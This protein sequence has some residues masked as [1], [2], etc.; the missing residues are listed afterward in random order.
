MVQLPG[1]SAAALTSQIK[2]LRSSLDL[3]QAVT[4]AE[5]PPFDV[6][7]S[8]ALY[9]RIMQP[10]IE[11]LKGIDTLFI[12]SDGPLASLPLALL[13]TRASNA[14][15]AST[16]YRN[17]RWLG[18]RYALVTLPSVNAL[19]A[20][21][22]LA[23]PSAA[24]LPLLALA[25]PAMRGS[26]DVRT[27]T[28]FASLRGSAAGSTLAQRTATSLCQM[29]ALPDTRREAL[30]LARQLGSSPGSILLGS[31]ASESGLRARQA[32]GTLKQYRTLLFA[33][34]GLLA[35]PD[36]TEEPALV[37]S[38]PPDCKAAAD[39]EDGLLTASEIA[40]F[41]LDA[42]LVVLSG[43]NTASGLETVSARPLSGLAAAFQ[44]AGAR[45]LLVSHW[46]VDSAA[47][48]DLMGAMFAGAG[49]ITATRLQQS[50]RHI[51]NS[52]GLLAYRAHPAFWAAF[53][54]VGD[55]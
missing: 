54:L 7:A 36:A 2:A 4:A 20:F 28:A 55:R 13:V 11:H 49:P 31:A 8:Q 19:V 40:T 18:D 27:L 25:D 44:Y 53:V 21:R 30:A 1:T 26:V 47:T 3:S 41:T 23:R 51:R 12:A 10:L 35:G 29:Q 48:A 15:D 37:L 34:H 46:S 43:C 9:A 52:T 24:Q 33:T 5:L 16:R 22:A 45:R 38:P 14:S 50:M 39:T 6:A 17:S 42:D 32:D